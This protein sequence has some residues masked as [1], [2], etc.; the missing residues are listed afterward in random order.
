MNNIENDPQNNIYNDSMEIPLKLGTPLASPNES[1]PFF[2]GDLLLPPQPIE[3]SRSPSSDS[4]TELLEMDSCDSKSNTSVVSNS[5]SSSAAE[6]T[7]KPTPAPEQHG[8]TNRS[9]GK[10]FHD[11]LLTEI[12]PIIITNP[13]PVTAIYKKTSFVTFQKKLVEN[14]N[15]TLG[16]RKLQPQQQCDIDMKKNK[17]DMVLSK[18]NAITSLLPHQQQSQQHARLTIKRRQNTSAPACASNNNNLNFSSEFMKKYPRNV[19]Q[20]CDNS[21]MFL[22]ID[23]HGHAS[24]KGIFMYGNYLPNTAEAVECM[25]LPRLMSIN[26]HHF[27]FDACVFS[28]RNMYHK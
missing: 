17:K 1:L 5:S 21:N 16:S 22:Y 6:I 7:L 15:T 13:Q 27:Q 10:V 9:V 25:L 8:A 24:K 19:D 28:E 26:S 3:K 20:D 18:N 14:T 2:K 12:K 4:S 23:L 11:K